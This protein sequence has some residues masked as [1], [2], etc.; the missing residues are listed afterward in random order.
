VTEELPDPEGVSRRTFTKAAVALGGASA[1]SACLGLAPRSEEPVPSGVSDPSTL[2]ERQH[3]WNDR[4]R[5]DDDGNVALP[6]HQ[7]LLYLT[8]DGE[9]PPGADARSTVA[10][11]LATLDRAYERSS[12]GLV[13]SMAYSP[14][15][16]ERF[17]ASLP[18]NIDLPQPERL[19]PF[20]EPD[21]DTQDALLHLTS[22]RADVVLEAEEAITGERSQ[23][24]GVGV[25]ATLTDAMT[26][27][28]RRTG[29]EG[30]GLP[31]RNQ[32]VKGIPDSRPVPEAS[33]LFMGFKAGFA[34][35][36]ATEDYVTLDSGPFAGGT[37]KHLSNIRQRL[38]DWY[39]EQ[40][41][42]ERIVEMFSPDH[43]EQGL[44]EGVGE[45]L[46]ADSGIDEFID[47]ET[48]REGIREFGRVGH[49]QKAARAN[50]DE[51][52]NVRILRRHFESTDDDIASLHFPSLQQRISTFEEVRRA[53]NGQDLTDNPSVRQ[54]VNNGILEYIFTERRGNF[55]V[56]PRRHRALPGPR[57]E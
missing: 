54:R 49:A 34:G 53:M 57:P 45:N 33:P 20:E 1:L 46:G 32:D 16:F 40:D 26:V 43:A 23:A 29:F 39:V 52:G 15:Y 13:Y 51:E 55:L 21:L 48:I 8:L 12:E 47:S 9:G 50:R 44:V 17:E 41:Q 42:D 11:A 14:S 36:Q 30:P 18:E 35:N 27:D 2:P 19:S 5:T 31:A 3:A 4:V 6:N 7:T 25:A 38:Q 37:T 22:D 24:N 56:P 10:D 28:S